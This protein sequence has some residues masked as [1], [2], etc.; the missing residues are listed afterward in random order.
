MVGVV[1]T[2]EGLND[3]RNDTISGEVSQ[4]E[5]VRESDKPAD[6]GYSDGGQQAG[7]R[8]AAGGARR[9]VSSGENA[10][11]VVSVDQPDASLPQLSR[12]AGRESCIHVGAL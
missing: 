8:R 2:S 6:A 5:G 3:L 11:A 9:V 7:S 12:G 10:W 4:T 1:F